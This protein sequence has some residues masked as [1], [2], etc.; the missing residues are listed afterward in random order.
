[1]CSVKNIFISAA[2]LPVLVLTCFAPSLR[3]Q[4]ITT[5]PL[6]QQQ[7]D[8]ANWEPGGKYWPSNFQNRGAIVQR[9]GNVATTLTSKQNVGGFSNQTANISGQWTYT[10]N[11]TAYH[12]SNVHSP[13]NT[14]NS[15][16]DSVSN[17]EGSVT[18]NM[19]W[20]GAMVHPANGY[21]GAQ[22]GGYPPPDFARDDFTFT[23]AGLATG[24]YPI[25]VQ[26]QQQSQSPEQ[27][28]QPPQYQQR[29]PVDPRPTSDGRNA[30][31]GQTANELSRQQGN[32]PTSYRQTEL[33]RL[34][35]GLSKADV[36]VDVARAAVGT[37]QDIRL[38]DL[39][40]AAT[41]YGWSSDQAN[42]LSG[43][44]KKAG[45]TGEKLEVL[46][47]ALKVVKWGTIAADIAITYAEGERAEAFNKAVRAAV[48]EAAAWAG[49]V[50][51]AKAGAI[52][53]GVVGAHFAGIGAA[54]G[55]LF[56]GII[57]G[58]TGGWAASSLAEDAYDLYAR[59]HVLALGQQIFGGT[60]D[61]TQN[62]AANA[63]NPRR[64]Y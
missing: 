61:S 5:D 20:D 13:F 45:A 36:A 29:R 23:I 46:G 9:G 11:L 35:G 16:S 55:A 7:T 57:G 33:G 63:Y 34:G 39:T 17:A 37:Y 51:G 43:A 41:K 12:P 28:W 3:A 62:M 50:A 6:V 32:N 54:P 24:A 19:S 21:D 30:Q 56:G 22:G 14:I 15:A 1:M 60:G 58:I 27:Q 4:D 31:T 2:I 10:I 52:G 42:K 59:Q 44:I 26:E 53:G 18:V 47:K 40:E 64:G 49:R 25:S 38:G 8:R 48:V